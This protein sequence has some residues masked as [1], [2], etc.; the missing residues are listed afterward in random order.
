[1]QFGK[2][3]NPDLVDFTLPEDHSNTKEI[4]AKYIDNNFK[5]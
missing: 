4:L 5:L 3:T 2:V 1:M